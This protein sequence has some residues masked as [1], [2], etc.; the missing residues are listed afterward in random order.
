[1]KNILDAYTMRARLVPAILAGAPAFALAI[2]LVSWGS[3]GLTHIM[4]TIAITALF[5]AFSDVARRRGKAIEPSL[6]TKMGGLPTTTMLR[7]RDTSIDEET[8]K[9]LHAFISDKLAEQAPTTEQEAAS[10]EAADLY[11]ARGATWLRENTRDMK[12]FGLLFNENVNYGFHRNLLGLR[13]P[14][15]L[16]NGAI[17]ILCVTLLCL[18]WPIDFSDTF[19]QKL[20]VVVIIAIAHAAYLAIFVTEQGV[21][22]AAQLY[23]RQLL[24]ASEDRSLNK[25]E[26][27]APAARSRAAKPKNE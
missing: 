26:R 5:A 16:L 25:P 19:N 18:R 23:A 11:Y 6:V 17:V 21:F 22:Q 4:A 12:K 13:T 27:T 3:F 24:L 1:M 10:P 20:I 9:R 15:F 14:G 7:H 2:A 8:K